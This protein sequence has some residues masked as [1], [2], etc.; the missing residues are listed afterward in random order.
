[1]NKIFGVIA[2]DVIDS[3]SLC[4]ADLLRLSDEVDRCFADAKYYIPIQF[5]GRLIKVIR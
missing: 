2:A 3:T 5:W 4:R 1:M